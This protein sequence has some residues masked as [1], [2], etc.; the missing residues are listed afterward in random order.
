MQPPNLAPCRV[1]GPLEALAIREGRYPVTRFLLAVSAPPEATKQPA[2]SDHEP[3][4]E[5]GHA[6]D[7]TP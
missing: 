3:G 1:I 2:A 5:N 7:T 4:K 6:A